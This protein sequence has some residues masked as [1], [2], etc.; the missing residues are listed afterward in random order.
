MSQQTTQQRSLALSGLF[1]G[2][3]LLAGFSWC[4]LACP[5][6]AE[7]IR[8]ATTDGV[9]LARRVLGFS[10]RKKPH[11]SRNETLATAEQVLKRL[12]VQQAGVISG[13]DPLRQYFGILLEQHAKLFGNRDAMPEEA[14]TPTCGWYD[15]EKLYILP[16][17]TYREVSKAL[18]DSGR[19]F[20]LAETRLA[21]MLRERGLVPEP[22]HRHHTRLVQYG[23]ASGTFSWSI[24]SSF[25]K[26]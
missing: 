7:V 9:E 11:A 17:M 24:G 15:E 21:Q 14:F 6:P 25:H 23:A 3:F 18:R 5:E 16:R 13:E 26:P 12:A 22:R 2:G 1:L 4:G 20:P 8:S 19:V 10:D